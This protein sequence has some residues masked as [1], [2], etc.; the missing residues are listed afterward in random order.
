MT[1]PLVNNLSGTGNNANGSDLTLAG[2]NS[3]GVGTGGSLVFQTSPTVNGS[4][5]SVN[6]LVTA[7]TING[8]GTS[9]FTPS[10]ATGTT[11]SSGVVVNASSLTTGTAVYLTSTATSGKLLHLNATQTSGTIMDLSYGAIKTLTGDLIGLSYDLNSGNVIP[12]NQNVT[13]QLIKLP[14]TTN[15]HT[16]GTKLLNGLE[17]TFGSGSGINQ[18]GAGGTTTYNSLYATLP[19][20]TQT[21]GTLSAN[22]LYV[23]TSSS[24]TTGGTA[25]GININPTGVGAGSLNGVLIGDITGGAGTEYAL[26]IAG[27]GWDAALRVGSTTVINGAG[28]TQVQGGGR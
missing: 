25:N 13:A 24:I 16:S 23:T 1:T 17:V 20:L 18:N 22:G 5:S 21:A 7:L 2:G 3:T 8:A 14:T 26:N 15:T 9:T 27:T 4:G 12:T 10:N 19:A 6:P 11:T 28:I